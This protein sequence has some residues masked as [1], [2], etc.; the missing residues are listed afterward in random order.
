MP[1]IEGAIARG[2]TSELASDAAELIDLA[3]GLPVAAEADLDGTD[4]T[5]P[6]SHTPTGAIAATYADLPAAR[7]S[8]NTLRTDVEAALDELDDN[9]QLAVS[10]AEARLDDIEATVNS[11]LAK[12][13]TAGVVTA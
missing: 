1:I 10:E 7:T 3:S 12:L 9:V 13:R 6:P 11:L 5:T 2:D 8:V 4:L